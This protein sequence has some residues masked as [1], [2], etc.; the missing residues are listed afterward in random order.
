MNSMSDLLQRFPIQ[1]HKRLTY[2]MILCVTKLSFYFTKR[3]HEPYQIGSKMP[4]HIETS[5]FMSNQCRKSIGWFLVNTSFYWKMFWKDDNDSLY[6]IE[7][8]F[9]PLS[10]PPQISWKKSQ[11]VGTRGRLSFNN[12]FVPFVFNIFC[13]RFSSSM[14]Y[15]LNLFWIRL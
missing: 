9:I 13:D 3:K 11:K 15:F 12:S 14:Q 1:K 10:P 8:K 2:E 5:Q 6:Q 4:C 7:S